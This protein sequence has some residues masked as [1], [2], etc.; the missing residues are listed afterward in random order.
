MSTNKSNINFKKISDFAGTEIGNDLVHSIAA[1]NPLPYVVLD[2]VTFKVELAN[3]LNDY[4]DILDKTCFSQFHKRS[5]QCTNAMY[6]CPIDELRRTGKPVVME[7]IHSSGNGTSS[8]MKLHAY[9]VM[10][11]NGWVSKVIIYF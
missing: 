2:A 10:D 1:N 3:G 11:D 5:L 7:H 8:E 4:G 6:P 9:P